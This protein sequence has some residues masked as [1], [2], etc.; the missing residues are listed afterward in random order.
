MFSDGLPVMT[1][2]RKKEGVAWDGQNG[3]EG[4]GGSR[5]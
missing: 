5:I 4:G 1:I 3:W 2:E